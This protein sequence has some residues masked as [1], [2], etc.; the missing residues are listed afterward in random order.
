MALVKARNASGKSA[1]MTAAA[2]KPIIAIAQ[3]QPLAAKKRTSCGCGSS[4]MPRLHQ[5]GERNSRLG[6]A[7]RIDQMPT[8]LPEMLD[9]HG[10]LEEAVRLAGDIQFFLE[11]KSGWAASSRPSRT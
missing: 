4:A 7:I 10:N 6:E 3:N 11:E 5:E 2:M 8:S 9:L 1:E